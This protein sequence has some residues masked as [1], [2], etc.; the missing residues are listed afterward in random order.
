MYFPNKRLSTYILV[1]SIFFRL[2]N[3]SI[4]IFWAYSRPRDSSVANGH[5]QDQPKMEETHMFHAFL[6]FLMTS[7]PVHTS[8]CRSADTCVHTQA[9]IISTKEVNPLC[10]K[11][12]Y[13]KMSLYGFL[14]VTTITKVKWVW[15]ICHFFLYRCRA[16]HL[17]RIYMETWRC[18]RWSCPV[19]DENVKVPTSENLILFCIY[20]MLC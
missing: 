18:K 19:S 1:L 20:N 13:N 5:C 9:R 3:T 6:F 10:M 2:T 14:I 15:C 8:V 4:H 11:L 12:L 16:C 17:K 7:I